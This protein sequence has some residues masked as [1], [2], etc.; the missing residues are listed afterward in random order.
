MALAR[1]SIGFKKVRLICMDPASMM[2]LVWVGESTVLVSRG[3]MVT[4]GEF[5]AAR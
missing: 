1:T 5:P 4:V 2:S 3:S